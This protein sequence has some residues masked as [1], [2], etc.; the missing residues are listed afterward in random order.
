MGDRPPFSR[1]SCAQMPEPAKAGSRP[2]SWQECG[3]TCR[4]HQ[5]Q[6]SCFGPPSRRRSSASRL[7]HGYWPLTWAPGPGWSWPFG[8][9][10]AA[11]GG[12]ASPNRQRRK[13]AVWRCRPA[14]QARLPCSSAGRAVL[15]EGGNSSRARMVLV[16][17]QI[18][19]GIPPRLLLRRSLRLERRRR[20]G[21]IGG[22]ERRAS[23]LG[24][25]GVARSV[26][27]CGSPWLSR[28]P[29]AT[30]PGGHRPPDRRA[31][32]GAASRPGR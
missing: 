5:R 6:L 2:L 21:Q 18:E 25:A 3:Q 23:A 4:N 32:P 20:L 14:T 24:P 10:W 19:H 26:A 13:P 8:G 16:F 15:A 30:G 27:G 1:C 9:G 17:S 28:P 12:P 31:K 29:A 11:A 22:P 7:G